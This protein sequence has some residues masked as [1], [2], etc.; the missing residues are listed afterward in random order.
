MIRCE[1]FVVIELHTNKIVAIEDITVTVHHYGFY[2]YLRGCMCFLVDI[3][4][5]TF[6]IGKEGEE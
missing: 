1:K 5:V 6:M 3:Q 4:S 2:Y